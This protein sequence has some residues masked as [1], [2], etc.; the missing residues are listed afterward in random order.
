M[1]N[2]L[3]VSR[4]GPRTWAVLR[5]NGHLVVV[6]VEGT[7]EPPVSGRIV[8]AVVTKV[9]PGTQSAFVDLGLERDGY[10]HASELALHGNPDG[11]VAGARIEG[12]IRE[13]SDLLVQV[14]RDPQGSKGSRVTCRIALPG[15]Y[16]VF[17][18][19]SPQGGGSRRITDPDERERLRGVLKALAVPGGGFI[20]RSAAEGVEADRFR[21]DAATLVETWEGIEAR[22]DRARAPSTLHTDLELPLRILRD[23]PREAPDRVFVDDP[24]TYRRIVEHFRETS[25]T[26]AGRLLLHS[27]PDPLM[28]AYGLEPEIHKAFRPKVWLK[29][30]GYLVVEQTE[31]L[32]S[33]DVNTGRFT[34]RRLPRETVLATNLEAVREVARQLR[35]RDLG[36]IIVV[37]VIDM[38]SRAD[39]EQVL[40]E[41][42]S[43]LEDD[44]DRTKVAGLSE[45]GLLLLTRRR[46]HCGPEAWLSTPCPT[47]SGHGRVKSP[48]TVACEALAEVRRLLPSLDGREVT[49]RTHPTVVREIDAVLLGDDSGIDKQHWP[50]IHIEADPSLRPDHFDILS[51]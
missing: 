39:R 1:S 21:A 28:H 13:G 6:R 42:E 22:Y 19:G 50:K 11:D 20:L 9:V 23:G 48:E 33:I 8:K 17:L 51:L 44:R 32:V 24:E 2:E 14:E 34:G 31:A 7:G 30:G 37:D 16:L 5:E 43:V 10:L 25:P 4:T 12:R 26:I 15:R 35:L 38:A 47:C 36:G 45:L 46:R 18:P 27:D 3:F 49:V 41:I 29:S 40:S